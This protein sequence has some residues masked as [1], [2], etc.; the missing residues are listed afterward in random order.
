MAD[1]MYPCIIMHNMIIEDKAN[2]NLRVLLAP[3]SSHS[4]LRRGFTFNNLQVITSKLQDSKSYYS[5]HDNLV[6]HL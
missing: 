2:A 1:V 3:S 5:L 4:T 6:Q